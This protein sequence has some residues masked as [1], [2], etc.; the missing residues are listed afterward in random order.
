[1]TWP[2]DPNDQLDIL[3]PWRPEIRRLEKEIQELQQKIDELEDDLIHK[4]WKD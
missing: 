3:E 2:A 1:M 4:T